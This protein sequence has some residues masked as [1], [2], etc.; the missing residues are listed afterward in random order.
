MGLLLFHVFGMLDEGLRRGD[1][2]G[3][4]LEEGCCFDEPVASLLSNSR[5]R[6]AL[7][8]RRQEVAL[9]FRCREVCR[10]S[11]SGVGLVKG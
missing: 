6:C 3:S 5:F 2:V 7:L 1:S 8:V 4:F 11:A 9:D 10:W